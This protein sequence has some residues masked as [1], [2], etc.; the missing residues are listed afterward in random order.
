MRIKV[1][2]K[3]KKKKKR[4]MR[5]HLRIDIIK[6]SVHQCTLLRAHSHSM[7]SLSSSA[8]RN[9][10]YTCQQEFSDTPTVCMCFNVVCATICNDH[11]FFLLLLYCMIVS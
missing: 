10:K 2:E 9:I 6:H 3:E 5:T 8:C 1:N 11:H 4:K 7:L